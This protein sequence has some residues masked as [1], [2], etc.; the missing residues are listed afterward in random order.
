MP[1]TI[2]KT[3]DGLSNDVRRT[4]RT[5]HRAKAADEDVVTEKFSDSA[6]ADNDAAC[7]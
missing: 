3:M 6:T 2:K 4:L 5:G 7:L 1:A